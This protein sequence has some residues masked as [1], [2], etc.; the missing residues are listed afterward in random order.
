MGWNA[1]CIELLDDKTMGA[2]NTYGQSIRKWPENDSLFIKFQGPTDSSILESI[3]LAKGIAQRHGAT[4]FEMAKDQKEAED[5][6]ADRKNA[7][8]AALALMPGCKSWPTDVWYVSTDVTTLAGSEVGLSVPV[9]KLPELVSE[10]KQDIEEAGLL[11]T[12]LGHVGDG[13]FTRL[14]GLSNSTDT[15][16]EISTRCYCSLRTKICLKQRNS[17]TGW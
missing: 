15:V 1:E 3:Q 17:S 9:S 5:L 11:G 13:E 7:H 6:W 16:Q 12:I 10:T 2:I 14:F 8:Y 4:R